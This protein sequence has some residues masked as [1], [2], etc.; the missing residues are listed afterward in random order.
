MNKVTTTTESSIESGE[1]IRVTES[2]IRYYNGWF[3]SKLTDSDTTFSMEKLGIFRSFFYETKYLTILAAR[4]VIA[5]I[6]YLYEI[7][8]NKY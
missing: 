5:D 4:S 1:I 2:N 8:T 3:I 6:K 7:N